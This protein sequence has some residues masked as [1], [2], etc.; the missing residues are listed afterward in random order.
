MGQGELLTDKYIFAYFFFVRGLQ[1][2]GKM[3]RFDTDND[4]WKLTPCFADKYYRFGK[5]VCN[6]VSY[7]KF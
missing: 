4:G 5:A 3:Q 1:V 2:A 6:N 7:E